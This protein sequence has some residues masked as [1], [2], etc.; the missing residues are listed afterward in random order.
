MV[1]IDPKRRI[2][3]AKKFFGKFKRTES[4]EFK[5][6]RRKA[7]DEESIKLKKL[8]GVADLERARTQGRNIARRRFG[9]GGLL[10]G[11]TT[12]KLSK[13]RSKQVGRIAQNFADFAVPPAIRGKKPK[14]KPRTLADML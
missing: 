4:E 12:P 3:D 7:F 10:S 11:T 5:T 6:E 9:S 13:G 8:K 14:R 2:R 1:Q